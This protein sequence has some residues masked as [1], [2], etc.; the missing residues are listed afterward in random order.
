MCK[1]VSTCDFR[2]ALKALVGKDAQGLFSSTVSR[3]KTIWED[4][5]EK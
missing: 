1:G 4:E 3:L 2:D 5:H